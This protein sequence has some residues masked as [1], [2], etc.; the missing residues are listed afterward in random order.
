MALCFYQKY[1]FFD[2]CEVEWGKIIWLYWFNMAGSLKTEV[3][4]PPF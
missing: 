3:G 4:N 2:M 1:D